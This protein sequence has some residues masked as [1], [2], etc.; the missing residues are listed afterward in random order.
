MGTD[1][2]A[3]TGTDKTTLVS[4]DSQKWGALLRATGGQIEVSAMVS[5]E[6]HCWAL[7]E[8]Q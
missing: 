3:L 8:G 5:T 1:G 2:L 7:T 4:T 6:G